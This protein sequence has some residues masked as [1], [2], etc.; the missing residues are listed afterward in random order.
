MIA[1]LGQLV[2]GLQRLLR[3]GGHLV[4]SHAGCPRLGL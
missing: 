4:E 3:L 2:C 1:L